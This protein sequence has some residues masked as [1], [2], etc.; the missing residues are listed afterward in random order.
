MG[1]LN[2]EQIQRINSYPEEN[3]NNEIAKDMGINRKTV[4]R[5]RIKESTQQQASD[6]L[7]G[8]EEQ[9]RLKKKTEQNL[10]KGDKKKLELLEHYSPKDIQEMLA[11]IA[12]TNKKEIDK[13]IGEP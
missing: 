11:Y 13:V 2:E 10:S 4:A 7:S 12:A 5:Y 9:M 8:K 3:S 1:K 6:V